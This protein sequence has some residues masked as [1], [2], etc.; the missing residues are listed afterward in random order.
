MSSGNPR[1]V[2]K[3]LTLAYGDV[4]MNSHPAIQI[5]AGNVLLK[6]V[7]VPNAPF[8]SIRNDAELEVRDCTNST[9]GHAVVV[10]GTGDVSFHGF[11][12]KKTFTGWNPNFSEGWARI[13]GKNKRNKSNG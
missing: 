4:K 5:N 11:T 13:F 7:H 10:E 6:D 2:I 12:S 1:Q 9:P 8:V 3:G